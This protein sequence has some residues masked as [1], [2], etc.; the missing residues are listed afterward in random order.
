MKTI[1]LGEKTFIPVI[2]FGTWQLQGGEAK[3]A[4]ET[5]LKA[6]YRH[7]DTADV[8]GNHQEVGEAMIKSG[9]SRNEI[10][11]TTKLWTN[12]FRKELVRPA[13]ERFLK[14]LKTDYIDLLLMHWPNSEVPAGETLMAMD[15]M[16]K[17]GIV[18]AIGVSNF[19]IE[20]LQRALETGIPFCNNQV[21]FHPSLNQKKL[22]DFCD[23]NGI[24]LTAYSPIAQGKDLKL[25]L[26]Q[27]LSEKYGRST[28]QVVLNWIISKGIVAIPR[29]AKEEHIV[30]NFKTLEWEMDPNDVELM[31]NLNS[32][33]RIVSPGFGPEWDRE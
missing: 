28:S 7:V 13:V 31:D 30:D 32:N 14:E 22:K 19:T 8:Y 26:V 4:V 9:V 17:E 25:P 2:G 3:R 5:A 20:L 6:G 21:E 29:S 24:I 27:E 33:N 18:K 11:L 1:K 10:F 12:S 16:K 15:K 23:Q